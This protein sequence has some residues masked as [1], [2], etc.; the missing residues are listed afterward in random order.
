MFVSVT[1]ITCHF[2]SD[3]I[4]GSETFHAA[5]TLGLLTKAACFVSDLSLSPLR[6]QT[7]SFRPLDHL[8][9]CR[10]SLFLSD[11]IIS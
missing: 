8:V 1:E 3:R 6:R 11:L 2:T 7:I 5:D 9:C 4:G 10:Q